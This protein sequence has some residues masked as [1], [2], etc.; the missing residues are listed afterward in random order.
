MVW[1]ALIVLVA[2]AAGALGTLLELA[3]WAVV[4][5]VLVL[6]AGGLLLV[7]TVGGRGSPA[8]RT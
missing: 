2:L 6:V 7:K 1:I 3:L 4:L 8:R 5:T